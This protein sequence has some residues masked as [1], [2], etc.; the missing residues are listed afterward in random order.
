MKCGDTEVSLDKLKFRGV[1]VGDRK[2]LRASVENVQGT[3][4]PEED[5]VKMRP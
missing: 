2:G 4:F 5:G 1:G 3:P